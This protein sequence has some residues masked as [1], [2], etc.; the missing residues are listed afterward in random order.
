MEKKNLIRT[1]KQKG[2]S[3]QYL[4]EHLCMDVSN[5]NKREK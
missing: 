3:Q 5:Y 1:R 2:F 4:A